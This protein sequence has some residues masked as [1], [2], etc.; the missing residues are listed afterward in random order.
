M[1]YTSFH[2]K[3][4]DAHPVA[5]N[6]LDIIA[7]ALRTRLVKRSEREIL[8]AF[9]AAALPRCLDDF[10]PRLF[11]DAAARHHI[12]AETQGFLLHAGQL[13]DFQPHRPDPLESLP[14]R[15]IL[16]D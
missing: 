5:A 4:L 14:M 10:Q 9:F 3:F 12:E 2:L 6:H 15:R 11:R 16:D 7:A 8:R 1:S 13:A